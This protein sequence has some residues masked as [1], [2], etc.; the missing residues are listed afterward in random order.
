MK[1]SLNLLLIVFACRCAAS[2][3]TITT[4]S[5]PN[6]IAGTAYSAVI[7]ASGG[8]TPYKWAIVSGRLPAGVSGKPSTSTTAFNLSGNPTGLLCLHRLCHWVHWA[9]APLTGILHNSYP[10][11]VQPYRRPK[12]EAVNLK[13]CRRLQRVSLF[14]RGDM[15]E[16]QR[17]PDCRDAVHRFHGC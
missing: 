7:S 9:W 15:E 8:C 6:G 14:R 16:N 2:N 17:E 4:T 10:G 12:L 13:R 3:V 11:W 1:L 5:V